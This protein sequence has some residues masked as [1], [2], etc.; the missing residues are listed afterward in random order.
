MARMNNSYEKIMYLMRKQ[1]FNCA[2]GLL[3]DSKAKGSEVHHRLHNTK[4]NRKRYP[5]FIN[6]IFNLWWVSHYWHMQHPS[7]GKPTLIMADEIEVLLGSCNTLRE[8]AQC[9]GE[10]IPEKILPAIKLIY[11]LLDGTEEVPDVE[12]NDQD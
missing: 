9:P 12:T 1:D 5:H 2:I 11:E 3:K 6:S 10:H 4:P 7:A 8:W